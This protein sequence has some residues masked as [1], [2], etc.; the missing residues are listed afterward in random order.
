MLGVGTFAGLMEVPP[1]AQTG[2]HEPAET[3]L[4]EFGAAAT[5]AELRARMAETLGRWT[6]AERVL[7]LEGPGDKNYLCTFALGAP[8]KPLNGQGAL[9]RWLRVNNE[10]LVFKDRPDVVGYLSPDERDYINAIGSD[11]CVPLVARGALVGVFFLCQ[12]RDRRLLSPPQ[13]VLGTF[14]ARAAEMWRHVTRAEDVQARREAMDQSQRLGIAGQ[15]AASVA[16]E[17]RNPLAA[18]RSLVQFAR[19]T[20][21]PSEEHHSVLT[22]VLEEVDRIDQ[23]VTGML[24]LSQPPASRR[25]SIDLSDLLRSTTRFVRAYGQ[26]RGVVISVES[27]DEPIK[28]MGD[29]R[30]LRQ[31]I[32]NLLLNACQACDSGQHVTA[33]ARHQSSGSQRPPWAVIEVRDSGSGIPPEHLPRIF[34]A[35]FTTKPQ[36]TGLSLPFCR[37]VAER[38]GGEVAVTSVVG[39]GTVAQ[40]RLPIVGGE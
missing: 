31:V 2:A 3:F 19:D 8:V 14:A 34:E 25:R 33:M 15:V 37:D 9:I 29:D 5:S 16:H 1:V 35:F 6:E 38:H 18:I 23:T 12:V 10:V 13:T 32:T 30:E 28:V 22:D 26:R 17:V 24:Q 20:D 40:V 11:A 21:L 36:G 7:F 39:E 4:A 27:S